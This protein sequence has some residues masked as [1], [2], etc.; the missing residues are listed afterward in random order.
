[1][2]YDKWNKIDG[3]S[4]DEEEVADSCS[5]VLRLKSSADALFEANECNN[6]AMPV[7][8]SECIS[9][10]QNVVGFASDQSLDAE[11]IIKC[12]LNLA[13]CFIRKSEWLPATQHA[14]LAHQ[15]CSDEQWNEQLRARYF[16]VYALCKLVSHVDVADRMNFYEQLIRAERNVTVAKRSIQLHAGFISTQHMSDYD[17]VFAQL[18]RCLRWLD[19]DIETVADSHLEKALQYQRTHCDLKV[20]FNSFFI[21]N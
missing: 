8:Y 6:S 21:T 9:M 7:S 19:T 16:E 17:H 3:Q 11:L 4:D 12:H 2:N 5:D 18:D 20:L 15:L 10:Y 14:E 1:M 13:C